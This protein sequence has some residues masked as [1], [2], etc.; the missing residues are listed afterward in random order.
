MSMT[1]I[2][3]AGRA[4]DD[5]SCAEDA[6]LFW[7]VVGTGAVVVTLTTVGVGETVAVDCWI[8]GATAVI[9]PVFVTELLP[10]PLIAMSEIE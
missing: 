3:R 4:Q 1:M 7:V 5:I 6:G 9:Y 8:A 2:T 10:P